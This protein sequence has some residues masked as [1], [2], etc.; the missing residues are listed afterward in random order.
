MVER[1]PEPIPAEE[2]S[3]SVIDILFDH[4]FATRKEDTPEIDVAY[5]LFCHSLLDLEPIV[6]DEIMSAAAVLCLEYER[7]AYTAGMKV[8]IRL[9]RELDE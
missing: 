8:K 1:I 9:L 2:E 6:A 5:R 4:Y 7:A 3:K